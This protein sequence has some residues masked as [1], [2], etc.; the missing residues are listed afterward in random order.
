MSPS[1]MAA[2]TMKPSCE[3]LQLPGTTELLV[4]ISASVLVMLSLWERER[5]TQNI[6]CVP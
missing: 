2:G 3:R 1:H 4:C 5:A 6:F